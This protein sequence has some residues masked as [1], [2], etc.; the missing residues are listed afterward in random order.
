MLCSVLFSPSFKAQVH[1]KMKLQ[2][3]SNHPH[4]NRGLDEALCFTKRI[5]SVTAK[6]RCSVLL[7][8]RS[9]WVSLV[10]LFLNGLSL[11]TDVFSSCYQSNE[12]RS[13][14]LLIRKSP[15]WG[16][17]TCLQMGMGA[18]ARLFF[19]HDGVQVCLTAYDWDYKDHTRTKSLTSM[20]RLNQFSISTGL[21]KL[22]FEHAC[23]GV[24]FKAL[25][26]YLR[27]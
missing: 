27:K 4:A 10:S 16:G 24:Q 12:S 26:L 8:S 6:R 14:T 1:P 9:E 20:R 3:L 23:Q 22:F 7:N 13:F 17:T 15:V 2:T 11:F 18:D 19:S 5:W 25:I 21:F